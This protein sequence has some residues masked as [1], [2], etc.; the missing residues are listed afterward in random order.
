[1][2][3]W[4]G[5]KPAQKT[6]SSDNFDRLY[7]LAEKLISLDKGYVCHCT[8]EEVNLQRGGPDN[9]GKR[10]ACAHRDRP[11]EESLTEFRAMRDGKYKP[12][13]AHLRMKQ[14][15]TDPAEGNPQMWDLA[16]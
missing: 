7:E 9:R 15:L 10:F 11:I 3:A 2:I 8:K 12:G 16:A 1:M 4:L 5:F 14:S 6:H 13:A